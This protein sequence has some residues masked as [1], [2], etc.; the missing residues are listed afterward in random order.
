MRFFFS[1]PR[2]VLLNTVSPGMTS[3]IETRRTGQR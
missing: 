1:M 2:V 3:G